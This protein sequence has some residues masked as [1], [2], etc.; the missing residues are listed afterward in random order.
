MD[1]PLVTELPK[2]PAYARD[3]L[4]TYLL[5]RRVREI[6]TRYSTAD[7]AS[8][9]GRPDS[10][11]DEAFRWEVEQAAEWFKGENRRGEG[12]DIPCATTT[13]SFDMTN[14]NT[15]PFPFVSERDMLHRVSLEM[16]FVQHCLKFEDEDG[17]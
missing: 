4:N 13:H 15:T 16:Q 2:V 5:G 6:I 3:R 14:L 7:N 12:R 1:H 11:L 8:I 10:M 17:D 9:P